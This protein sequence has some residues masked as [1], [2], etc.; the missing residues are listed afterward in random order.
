MLTFRTYFDFSQ[1]CKIMLT[2]NFSFTVIWLWSSALDDMLMYGFFLV[3][4]WANRPSLYMFLFELI[5]PTEFEYFAKGQD[6]S[7]LQANFLNFWSLQF[8]GMKFWI[9]CKINAPIRYSRDLHGL[10]VWHSFFKLDTALSQREGNSCY[11]QVIFF[12][13]IFMKI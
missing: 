11:F 7:I 9:C 2:V 12:L 3:F 13:G 8:F 4:T 6:I 1:H 5:L 10:Y